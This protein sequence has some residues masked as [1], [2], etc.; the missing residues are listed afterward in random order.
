MPLSGNRCGAGVLAKNGL[1]QLRAT[2][3][4]SAGYP[5]PPEAIRP[6]AQV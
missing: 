4:S 2:D 3:R 5:A 1:Q 6:A